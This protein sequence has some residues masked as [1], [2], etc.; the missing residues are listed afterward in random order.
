MSISF[1]DPKANDSFSKLRGTDLHELLAFLDTFYLEYRKK[2][3][4]PEKLGFGIE[5]EYE[6]LPQLEVDNYFDQTFSKLYKEYWAESFWTSKPDRSVPT[7]GEIN[8]P[9]LHD[10][11]MDW[12]QL[13]TV[14][15]F[16]DKNKVDMMHNAGCHMHFSADYLGDDVEA[17]R[18]FAKMYSIYEPILFRFFYGDMINARNNLFFFAYPSAFSLNQIEAISNIKNPYQLK[19]AFLNQDKRAAINFKNVNFYSPEI[20]D[21]K[22]TIEDRT[23][24]G[25]R[26]A[27][28]IQNNVNTMGKFFVTIVEKL[29][30]EEFLDW[31][32]KH[33]KIYPYSKYKAMYNEIVLDLALEFADANFD[34][35]LDK[36]Y[37]LRQ[38]LK[39]FE[40]N[41]NLTI[42]TKAK[43]FTRWKLL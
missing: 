37:F 13:E 32:L 39:G 6:N 1:I 7:G 34:N 3:D 27:I 12:E 24:N 11:P 30:D 20:F 40:D 16:L 43:K 28:I 26:D 4:L 17:W 14:M 22:N 23:P 18:L 10:I 21:Y 5:I 33:E 2:L 9:V 31:K 15:R 35:N 19:Y 8:S 38:Y 42:P 25:T 36:V 41:Y 29:I